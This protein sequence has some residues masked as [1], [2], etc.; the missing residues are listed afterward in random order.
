MPPSQPAD[1]Q[2]GSFAMKRRLPRK[3]VGIMCGVL[4]AAPLIVVTA[5]P[6]AAAGPEFLI[7]LKDQANN[8]QCVSE[9][10]RNQQEWTQS[11]SPDR[12]SEPLVIDT[13]NRPGGCELSFGTNNADGSLTGLVLNYTFEY[14][15]PEWGEPAQ[16]TGECPTASH[17]SDPPAV[18][19]IPI[20]V[21]PF[22]FPAPVF[23][24]KIAI[25][26]DT[27][28]NNFCFLTFDMVGST[29]SDIEFVVKWEYN[30]DGGQCGGGFLLGTDPL[31]NRVKVG[32]EPVTIGLNTS[33]AGGACFLSFL[34]HHI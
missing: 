28:R 22:A 29:R 23:A 4:T 2:L 11:V 12:W 18:K 32:A 9:D 30:G 21:F 27:Q 19:R 17:S 13:D 20:P 24:P 15:H 14:A 1:R 3:L 34:W 8:G 33:N 5:G 10:H 26:T 31:Q 25:D 7:T 16:R 6:A